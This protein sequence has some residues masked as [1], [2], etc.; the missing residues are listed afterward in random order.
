M[1]SAMS[2]GDSSSSKQVAGQSKVAI[3][4]KNIELSD[5]I[6]LGQEAFGRNCQI[7]HNSKGIGG[8]CPTLIKGAWAPDGPNSDEIMFDII[9]NGRPNTQMGAFGKS[10][11][12]DEIWNI[13]NYLRYEAE[14]H[15]QEQA[16]SEEED[17]FRR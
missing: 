12:E 3:D 4:Q 8:K 16:T 9:A 10:L 6:K 15:A 1:V 5:S 2:A 13:I 11:T 17:T 7:C 14:I